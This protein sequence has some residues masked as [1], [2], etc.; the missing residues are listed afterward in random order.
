[1]AT[2]NSKKNNSGNSKF[3]KFLKDNKWTTYLAFQLKQN[4][5]NTAET[6]LKY[7]ALL[8]QCCYLSRIAYSPADI[9]CR[10]T[11]HLDVTP[12]AFNNYIRAIEKIYQKLFNYKCSY[13]SQYIQEHPQYKDYFNPITVERKDPVGFFI[14][15]NKQLNVY[16][17]VY[18]KIGCKFNDKK[19]LYIAFKGSSSIKEFKENLM[20][21]VW[22]DAP[23]SDLNVGSQSGGEG[24]APF[25]SETT[26]ETSPLLSKT[27][28][29]TSLPLPG[30]KAGGGFINVLKNSIQEIC[31][32]IKELQSGTGFDR[33]IITGHSAGGV[34]ASLFGYYLK[35]YN[36]GITDKPIHVIT[37]GACCIFDAIGR[38]EFNN[39]LNIE[40]DK[41]GIFTLDRVTV[42]GDPI[43]L[44]PPDLDHPGFTLIKTEIRAFTKTGRTKEIGEL[45]KMLGLKGGYDGNDLLLSV[46]FVDLF[47]NA[48]YFKPGGTY[49]VNLYRSKFRIK[50]GT[51]AKE[52][53][54]ILNKA[55][56]NSK[57]NDVKN[58][59]K[60]IESEVG[61]NIYN[62]SG[63]ISFKK[64]LGEATDVYKTLT[65]EKMPNEIEYSCYKIM[66]LGFCHGVYMG[67]TYMTVLRV[68]GI[69]GG[70]KLKKETKNNYTLYK[71][72]DGKVVSL[73]TDSQNSYTKNS[74]C[75]AN[76]INN[77]KSISNS[78]GNR[79]NNKPKSLKNRFTGI[80]KSKASNQG[81]SQIELQNMK[82]N[83][84]RSG[85]GSGNRSGN[86]SG[87][88]RTNG[89]TPLLQGEQPPAEEQKSS[90]KCSIL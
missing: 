17:Y 6:Q 3:D 90:W 72:G 7:E 63:G 82:P 40:Q 44:L 66:S 85:N 54:L 51:N 19:T 59:F 50:F 48:D 78:T 81:S 46:K 30:G 15:N 53:H 34:Y 57:K 36:P 62:Q 88:R 55:M 39:F 21:A 32:K 28:N 33:I 52:Q 18:D 20:S 47:T 1:M 80:F 27:N 4:S 58:L 23:L 86:G 89:N 35:K 77:K 84:N 75:K 69:T 70:L 79:K 38:N 2:N 56:P 8:T 31:T 74:D 76:P 16:L 22:K 61:K 14:Q 60:T 26:T 13:D 83:G 10:M 67:V 65:K 87:N 29:S 68:P 25:E 9:F 5:T 71:Q 64:E 41:G 49:D 24:D 73:L 37:F 42:F 11:Q 45:R 43:I 12:N